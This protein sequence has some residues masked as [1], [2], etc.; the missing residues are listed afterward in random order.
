MIDNILTAVGI[1]LLAVVA[2]IVVPLIKAAGT[3]LTKRLDE[4]TNSEKLA[5][6]TQQAKDVVTQVVAATAQ[7]YVD[8]IKAAGSFD[9]EEQQKAL[10]MAKEAAASLISDEVREL[11]AANYNSFDGWLLCAIE[12]EVARSKGGA[13]K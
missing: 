11:I 4:R 8:D 10:E 7:T 6:A 13:R 9:A 3:A 1:I 2:Y 5:N 12:A